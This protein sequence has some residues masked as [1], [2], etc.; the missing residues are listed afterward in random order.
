MLHGEKFGQSRGTRKMFVP[1][2]RRLK[3]GKAYIFYFQMVGGDNVLDIF[4]EG[5]SDLIAP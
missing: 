3:Y 2:E 4:H 1:I 5:A